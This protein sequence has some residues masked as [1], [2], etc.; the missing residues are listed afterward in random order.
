ARER[1]NIR[2][3]FERLLRGG[4]AEDALRLAIAFARA[5]PWDAH[6][7]EVRGWLADGVEQ[8]G[9]PATG[10]RAEGF[11]W[12]GRLAAS[13]AGFEEAA[14]RLE[15]ALAATREAGAP[16]IEAATLAALGRRAT[17]VGDKDAPA[18]C[19]EALAVAR[20]VGEPALVADAL[21][22]LAGSC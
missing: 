8:L 12:D 15:A 20:R 13:Q 16:A 5:L 11:Y 3:A 6:T 19:E 7:H 17:L 14:A 18:L 21:L 10:L 22:N 1:P 4:A 9:G 2:L